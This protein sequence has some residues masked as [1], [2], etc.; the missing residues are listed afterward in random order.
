MRVVYFAG[1]SDADRV[2]SGLETVVNYSRYRAD[3][4]IS[5]VQI[6]RNLWL[7]IHRG[8]FADQRPWSV[9]TAL[10]QRSH[11]CPFY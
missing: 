10:D 11:A 1:R 7:R 6:W 3:C 4:G 9:L 5:R 2:L 8:I